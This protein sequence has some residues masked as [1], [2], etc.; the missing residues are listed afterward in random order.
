MVI[1]HKILVF[2]F[3][4]LEQHTT[5]RESM[6]NWF[7]NLINHNRSAAKISQVLCSSVNPLGQ[8]D[9]RF[10]AL[11]FEPFLNYMARKN[12][13][14]R[15]P[16]NELWSAFDPDWISGSIS[17]GSLLHSLKQFRSFVAILL[18]ADMI[19]AKKIILHTRCL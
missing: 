13:F 2:P 7:S 11:L 15:Y 6:I 16:S 8:P 14:H 12:Y 1:I 17:T 4:T 3:L 19:F 10:P 5:F 18:L 9:R